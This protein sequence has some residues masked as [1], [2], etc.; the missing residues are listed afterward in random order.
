[1]TRKA[2]GRHLWEGKRPVREK[3]PAIYHGKTKKAI[4]PRLNPLAIIALTRYRD[5]LTRLEIT[6]EISGLA[7]CCDMILSANEGARR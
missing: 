7:D 4:L 5:E 1:M 3:T 2:E 6:H